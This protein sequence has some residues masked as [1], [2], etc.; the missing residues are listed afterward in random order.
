MLSLSTICLRKI[1]YKKNKGNVNTGKEEEQQQLLENDGKFYFLKE[2][3][4]KK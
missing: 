4:E 3:S 2:K 1:Q